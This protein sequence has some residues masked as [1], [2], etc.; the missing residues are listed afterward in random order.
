MATFRD[1]SADTTLDGVNMIREFDK[2]Y[3]DFLDQKKRT[4]TFVEGFEARQAEIDAL[5]FDKVK[6]EQMAR[7]FAQMLEKQDAE[8]AKLKAE[9][10]RLRADAERLDFLNDPS[11]SLGFDMDDDS[12]F[13]ISRVTGARNDR[14]WKFLG[15][16]ESARTAI[17][18]AMMTST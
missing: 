18:V 15:K 2:W 8:L 14:E 9:N 12:P 3:L 6:F 5:N 4:P 11:I 1:T 7:N 17:D 10:E 16:G 13:Y